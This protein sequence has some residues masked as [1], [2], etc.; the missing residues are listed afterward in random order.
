MENVK[1]FKN[2]KQRKMGENIEI[3]NLYQQ[4]E[5]KITWFQNQLVI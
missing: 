3:L 1:K 5:E 4:K 2:V